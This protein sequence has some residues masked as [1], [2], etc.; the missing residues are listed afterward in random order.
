MDETQTPETTQKTQ[1]IE[2][3]EENF[4][5]MKTLIPQLSHLP[6]EQTIV[7]DK[8]WLKTE[9]EYAEAM[10]DKVYSE[11]VEDFKEGVEYSIDPELIPSPEEFMLDVEAYKATWED[12]KQMLLR[13][14]AT[15]HAESLAH[16]KAM[17]AQKLDEISMT[18]DELLELRVK[19]IEDGTLVTPREYPEEFHEDRKRLNGYM[20]CTLT[21]Y[22]ALLCGIHDIMKRDFP[23]LCFEFDDSKLIKVEEMDEEASEAMGNYEELNSNPENESFVDNP[24]YKTI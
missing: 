24:L 10:Y 14:F 1:V 4:E 3:N 19:Q 6:G 20:T 9:L 2:V 21:S 5:E 8:K 18:K 13:D 23:E 12:H 7:R 15:T 22:F 11:L 16:E 17:K